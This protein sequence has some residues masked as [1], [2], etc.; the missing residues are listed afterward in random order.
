MHKLD[1]KALGDLVA[2]ARR[3]E[4][5]H[6]TND[7]HYPYH[8]LVPLNAFN[9]MCFALADLA[10]LPPEQSAAQQPATDAADANEPIGYMCSKHTVVGSFWVSKHRNGYYDL[11]VYAALSQS[12]AKP[13]GDS[14]QQRPAAEEKRP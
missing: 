12:P 10:A 11:P 1:K 8:V 13:A 4:N 5:D 14:L 7:E 2:A 9:S 3:M 6:R